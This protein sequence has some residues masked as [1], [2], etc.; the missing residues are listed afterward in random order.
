MKTFFITYPGRMEQLRN[1]FSVVQGESEGDARRLIHS[2]IGDKW[3]FIYPIFDLPRQIK[4]FDL[5]PVELH[6]AAAVQLEENY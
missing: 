5:Q 6:T 1:A 4:Q 3:A 2:Y